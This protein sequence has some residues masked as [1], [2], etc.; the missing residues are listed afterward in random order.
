VWK[1]PVSL[2]LNGLTARTPDPEPVYHI[3]AQQ[4][5]FTGP[6]KEVSRLTFTDF[7]LC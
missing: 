7:S 6:G 3:R 5:Y 4:V 2:S 1:S